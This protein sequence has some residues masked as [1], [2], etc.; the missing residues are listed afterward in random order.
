M[1]EGYASNNSVQQAVQPSLFESVSP[2]DVKAASKDFFNHIMG[3]FKDYVDPEKDWTYM[4]TVPAD[5]KKGSA[6]VQIIF[7]QAMNDW[8]NFTD[9][10]TNLESNKTTMFKEAGRLLGRG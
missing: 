10:I 8:L 1:L 6:A 5:L 9:F 3:L 7:N 2:V 4:T